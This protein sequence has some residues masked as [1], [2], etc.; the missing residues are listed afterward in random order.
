MRL[1]EAFHRTL[2]IEIERCP[3]RAP[4]SWV[5]RHDCIDKVLRATRRIHLCDS[6]GLREK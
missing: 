4:Q 5:S 3:Y 6:R 1:R 2:Q